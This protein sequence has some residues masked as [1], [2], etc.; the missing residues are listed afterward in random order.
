[1]HLSEEKMFKTIDDPQQV[2]PNIRALLSNILS[3]IN[4]TRQKRL[5]Q[6]STSITR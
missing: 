6:K 1:M 3:L 2:N 4:A 5:Y